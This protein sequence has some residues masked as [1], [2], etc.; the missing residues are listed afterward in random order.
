[1]TIMGDWNLSHVFPFP[2]K[3][4]DVHD[5]TRIPDEPKFPAAGTRLEKQDLGWE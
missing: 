5:N 4:P 2:A 1:M 3:S